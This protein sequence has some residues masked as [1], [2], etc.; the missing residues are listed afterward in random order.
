MPD[1]RSTPLPRSD[2]PISRPAINP[3]EERIRKFLEALG[4]PTDSPPPPPVVPRSDIPPR[5]V[6][7]IQPP[8]EMAPGTFPTRPREVRKIFMPV[9]PAEEISP[10]AQP[11]PTHPVAPP[12][13][14]EVSQ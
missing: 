10:P 6:V 9:T 5:P 13:I 8:P 7:P 12:I 1:P 11:P 4:V 14:Q 2:Q 3:E